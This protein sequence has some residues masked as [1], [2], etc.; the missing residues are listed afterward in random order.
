MP[1]IEMRNIEET[2]NAVEIYR[3]QMACDW[4]SANL[5]PKSPGESKRIA[6]QFPA[7]KKALKL[8]KLS[9]I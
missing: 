8:L 6:T 1:C 2:Q 7:K 5:N 9:V 3:C 4:N